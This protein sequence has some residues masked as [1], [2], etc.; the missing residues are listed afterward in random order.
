MT[1]AATARADALYLYGIVRSRG[2]RGS[3]RGVDVSGVNRVRYRELEAITRA[4]PF[5]MVTVDQSAVREHQRVVEGAMRRATVLPFPC[6]VVFRDRR[7]LIRTLEEQYLVVDEALSFLE[8]HWEV[9]I[10]LTAR[11]DE[12]AA[13]EIR[14]LASHVYAELRRMAHAA[15][16]LAVRD[17]RILSA[18]FL[19]P[20]SAWVEFFDRAEDLA[21]TDPRL[22]IDI[23]GPWPAY[24]FVRVTR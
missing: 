21:G 16:P 3:L 5:T 6:G 24:D 2:F 15:H 19:V 14:D 1:A 18:A 7:E 10:H 20:R 4:V 22:G 12:E 9:R 17:R 13:P 23:T 8:G 11:G